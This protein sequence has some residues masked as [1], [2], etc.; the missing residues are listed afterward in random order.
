[1]TTTLQSPEVTAPPARRNFV[2]GMT[3]ITIVALAIRVAWVLIARRD[4]AL[5]GDDFFY[6]WQANALAD[7]KGFLDPFT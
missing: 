5:H 7:G 6:H 2:V 4:F 3:V 1:M